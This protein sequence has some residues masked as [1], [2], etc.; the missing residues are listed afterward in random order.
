MR[1]ANR[2][3]MTL[4][5]ALA[6]L[7]GFCR[8][9]AADVPNADTVSGAWQ[10]HKVTFSYVG[11]TSSFTCDGLELHV[12][13]ILVHL[14]ARQDAHVRASGCGGPY[15]TPT[16]SAW[17][18]TDFHTLAPVAD[19]AP[20]SVK[21][22]WAALEVTPR[23]PSFMGDG[24]CELIREM[25][26]LITQNFALRDVEYRTSCYPHTFAVDGFAVKGQS[27]QALP[28]A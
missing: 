15:N 5:G 4:G 17:V 20:G 28:R 12:R 13:Q 14:G 11:F 18:D 24:D 3:W 22:V 10:E 25:K 2:S 27:L 23:R 8:V 7:A 16:H 21:A 6:L 9:S 1:S 19:A 26:D